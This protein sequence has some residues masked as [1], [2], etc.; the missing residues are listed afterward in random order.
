MSKR[1]VVDLLRL[2]SSGTV[3]ALLCAHLEAEDFI[4]LASPVAGHTIEPPEALLKG[5]HNRTT[6]RIRRHFRTGN[7]FFWCNGERIWGKHRDIPGTILIAPAV[8][9]NEVAA[10]DFHPAHEFIGLYP[11]RM[12]IEPSPGPASESSKKLSTAALDSFTTPGPSSGDSVPLSE[13]QPEHFISRNYRGVIPVM[14][15]RET[16]LPP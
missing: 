13:L 15:K 16:A 10:R 11:N 6:K 12:T 2:G 9:P 1:I 5:Q 4:D 14:P 3:N 8:S 7:G